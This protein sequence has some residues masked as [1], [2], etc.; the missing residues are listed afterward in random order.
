MGINF[1]RALAR[2]ATG[3]LK[4]YA[5]RINA[6]KDAEVARKIAIANIPI[7]AAQEAETAKATHVYNSRT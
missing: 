6:E 5:D 3:A 2:A 1:G 7:V 4:P